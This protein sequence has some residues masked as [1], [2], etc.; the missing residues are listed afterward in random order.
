MK[1]PG[2][3]RTATAAPQVPREALREMKKLT[4]IA[5]IFIV[6]ALLAIPLTTHA[7][8]S[9]QLT[10]TFQP[11]TIDSWLS[12]QNINTNYGLD[13]TMTVKNFKKY[14]RAVVQFDLSQIPTGSTVSS[15]ILSLYASSVPTVTRTYY[16]H[17]L[18]ASWTEGAVTWKDPWTKAGGDY[19]DS[20]VTY[21]TPATTGWMDFTVTDDVSAFVAGTYS[22][23][24]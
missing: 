20:T 15:A 6:V 10:R 21:N 19:A 9:Q 7:A 18:T 11:S 2:W 13:T 23:Y 17:R 12:E 16:A 8:G 5:V 24:G 3:Y 22:N 14:G 4:L 1:R